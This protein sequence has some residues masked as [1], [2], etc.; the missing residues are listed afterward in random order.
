MTVN[1]MQ[2]SF[3]IA[4]FQQQLLLLLPPRLP[5]LPLLL[6]LLKTLEVIVAV[7]LKV[8]NH[9]GDTKGICLDGASGCQLASG[10]H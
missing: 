9:R 8:I 3:R 1:D 4:C 10:D 2:K 5:L 7:S 6:L